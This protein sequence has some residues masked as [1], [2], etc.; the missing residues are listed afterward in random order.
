MWTNEPGIFLMN[1]NK[2]MTK[3]IYDFSRF[4]PIKQISIHKSINQPE[5]HD[6]PEEYCQQPGS[7]GKGGSTGLTDRRPW[8]KSQFCQLGT[9]AWYLGSC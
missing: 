6:L 4:V 2:T 9:L 5:P 8:L 3:Q 1:K 7:C